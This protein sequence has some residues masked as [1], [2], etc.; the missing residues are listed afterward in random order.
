MNYPIDPNKWDEMNSQEREE[1]QNDLAFE[2]ENSYEDFDV[3][4]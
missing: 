4:E 1:Y 2:M 3:P